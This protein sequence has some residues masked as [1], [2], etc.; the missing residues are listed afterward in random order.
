[1]RFYSITSLLLLFSTLLLLSG[2]GSKNLPDKILT[3]GDKIP[4]F[5]HQ[6]VHDI[7]SIEIT[8][9]STISGRVMRPTIFFKN[10]GQIELKNGT[11][12][13]C[14]A[15]QGCKIDLLND[16]IVTTGKI[17]VYYDEVKM[18]DFQFLFSRLDYS[19]TVVK[20]LKVGDEFPNY[21]K[22]DVRKRLFDHFVDTRVINSGRVVGGTLELKGW[23]ELKDGTVYIIPDK[24]IIDFSTGRRV[25]TEGTI[26]CLFERN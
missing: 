26:V 16:W 18:E 2:C 25:I 24:C 1:M 12:Y 10:G 14:K 21:N 4:P 7:D 13:I 19:Q 20:T 8:E 3:V 5:R 11:R 9:P 23:I 22:E 6:D 15:R 17:E